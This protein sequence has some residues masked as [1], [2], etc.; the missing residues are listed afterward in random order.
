MAIF[1]VGSPAYQANSLGTT[2]S[3]VW[4]GT[5]PA[6][7]SVSPAAVVRDLTIINT[8]TATCYL[9]GTGITTTA[10]TGFALAPGV[11]VTLQGWTATTGTSTNDVYGFVYGVG[12]ATTVQAGL[13]TNAWVV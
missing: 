3:I 1:D 8:G 12:L 2:A 9:G 13:A 11:Q 5:A 6:I 10:T 4:S 7:G